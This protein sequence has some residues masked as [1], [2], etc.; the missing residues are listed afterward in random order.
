MNFLLSTSQGG[1]NGVLPFA[2]ASGRIIPCRPRPR[3]AQLNL[4]VRSLPFR[5][6]ERVLASA[7][8]V[9]DLAEVRFAIALA[10][11]VPLRQI[12]RRLACVIG[13]LDLSV[14]R[15]LPSIV[16]LTSPGREAARSKSRF[17][18]GQP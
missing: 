17:V 7:I 18:S 2:I 14:S 6:E 13:F 8:A 11:V 9:T 15:I 12:L 3:S 16:S 5:L 1:P 4:P 10:S